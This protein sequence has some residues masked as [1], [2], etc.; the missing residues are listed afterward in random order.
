MSE[1]K[2]AAPVRRMAK[3]TRAVDTVPP[4]RRLIIEKG[5]YSPD[6]EGSTLPP[7]R[8]PAAVSPAESSPRPKY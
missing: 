2:P 5:G 3:N 6:I 4:D 1:A 8:R 7:M